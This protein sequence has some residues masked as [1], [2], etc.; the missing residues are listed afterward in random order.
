MKKEPQKVELKSVPND[1]PIGEGYFIFPFQI[2]RI[3]GKMLT[4]IESLGLKE[5]QEK[6]TKDLTR[7]IIQGIYRDT[8]W[9]PSNISTLAVNEKEIQILQGVPFSSS[10]PQYDPP[11]N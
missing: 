7:D 2:A 4:L 5:G 9:L 11:F 8:I 3:E 6:A 10:S 1:S